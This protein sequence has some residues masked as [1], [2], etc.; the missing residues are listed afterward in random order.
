MY[1]DL[2][3]R[4]DE[5]QAQIA[6]GDVNAQKAG[7]VLQAIDAMLGNTAGEDDQLVDKWERELAEGK[8][9]DLNE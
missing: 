4:R 3:V 7:K 9:P 8:I 1:E 5:I 2:Y 6:E